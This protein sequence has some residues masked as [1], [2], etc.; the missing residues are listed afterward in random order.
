MSESLRDAAREKVAAT[1]VERVLDTTDE[2][3]AFFE[4][5]DERERG[6]EPD[7]DAHREVIERSIAAG[8]PRQ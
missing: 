3:R 4:A 7:W 8:A 6:R 1:E 5:C 2:P